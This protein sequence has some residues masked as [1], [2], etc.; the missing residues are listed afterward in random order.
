MHN[1]RFVGGKSL[2]FSFSEIDPGRLKVKQPLISVTH[3]MNSF[4]PY[5]QPLSPD[6]GPEF[7]HQR[8]Q[9]VRSPRLMT[10]S[11]TRQNLRIRQS[12]FQFLFCHPLRQVAEVWS[13]S[14]ETEEYSNP[15]TSATIWYEENDCCL[16]RP[17]LVEEEPV[18]Q[19]R[20]KD[21][22]K[23]LRLRVTRFCISVC[24]N[25]SLKFHGCI[26]SP[27][28]FVSFCAAVVAQTWTS[29]FEHRVG[30]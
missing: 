30:T 28:L 26:H 16:S 5:S 24:G 23:N 22:N 27:T 15:R 8:R 6:L 1:H 2:F 11:L 19:D 14:T 9:Q 20:S 18:L 29:N 21:Q 25:S 7:D 17:D 4:S 13:I 3:E 12:R 10:R